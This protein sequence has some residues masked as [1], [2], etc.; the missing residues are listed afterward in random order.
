MSVIIALHGRGQLVFWE[1][2]LIPITSET[3]KFKL[4][5]SLI[6]SQCVKQQGKKV[7]RKYASSQILMKFM[8]AAIRVLQMTYQTQA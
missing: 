4:R 1:V 5:A 8:A 7:S 2:R 3:H 6:C